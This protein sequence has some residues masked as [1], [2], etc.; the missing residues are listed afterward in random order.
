MDG[1]EAG[2]FD[3]T[4]MEF[5]SRKHLDF[6]IPASSY[7]ALFPACSMRNSMGKAKYKLEIV[8]LDR[9]CSLKSEEDDKHIDKTYTNIKI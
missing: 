8:F 3:R 2:S 4:L 6:V 7:R 9:K 5:L 1:G